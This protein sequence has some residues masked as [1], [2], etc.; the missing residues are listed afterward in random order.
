MKKNILILMCLVISSPKQV[1][2]MGAYQAVCEYLITSNF[3]NDAI[4][5]DMSNLTMSI[6][7]ENMIHPKNASE[8]H[9][10]VIPAIGSMNQVCFEKY[11]GNPIQICWLGCS[12]YA[13]LLAEKSLLK[14]LNFFPIEVES[15]EYID[16]EDF[17][18][19]NK[20]NIFE[21]SESEW[22]SHIPDLDFLGDDEYDDEEEY[23]DEEEGGHG[24]G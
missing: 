17:R 23:G 8:K 1:W 2:S 5:I 15:C 4:S 9:T 10:I 18:G 20:E 14:S 19:R 16:N 7:R 12:L 3:S 24:N 13:L 21:I 11:D 6:N 22:E